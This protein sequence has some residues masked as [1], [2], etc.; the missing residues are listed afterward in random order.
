MKLNEISALLSAICYEIPN[1]MYLRATDTDANTTLDNVNISGRYVVLF[2]NLPEV[3]V[4]VSQSGYMTKSTPIGIKVLRLAGLDDTTIESDT[5][6]DSCEDVANMIFDKIRIYQELPDV[7]EY[8]VSLLNEV[9][10]YDK[11]LTG[12]SMSFVLNTE[13]GGYGC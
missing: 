11:I 7:F 6:R 2:N 4:S 10:L 13:R 1:A 9:K 12:V 5:I 3:N 8:T